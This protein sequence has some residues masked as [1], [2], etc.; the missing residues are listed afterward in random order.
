MQ[1]VNICFILGVEK[2]F[3]N[4]T[5][6]AK[7]INGMTKSTW[8]DKMKTFGMAKQNKMRTKSNPINKSKRQNDRADLIW[9]DLMA[10]EK[11]LFPFF[12]KPMKSLLPG[13]AAAGQCPWVWVAMSL[14][15][16]GDTSGSLEWFL[17]A[18]CL[19]IP[20]LLP[21]WSDLVLGCSLGEKKKNVEAKV[22]I[23]MSEL[24]WKAQVGGGSLGS[25]HWNV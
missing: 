7:T 21:P 23:S 22:S 4:R 3:L 6:K 25:H 2:I 10:S 11:K 18:R 17:H 24:C 20:P 9:G 15:A 14:S 1:V 16:P 13:P 19:T 8:L 12:P 5:P